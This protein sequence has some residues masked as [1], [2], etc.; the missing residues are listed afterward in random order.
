MAWPNDVT[1]KDL[2]I[3]YLRGSG[4]GGQKRQKTSSACRIHH[5]PTGLIGYAEDTR[6]QSTNRELAFNRLVTKLVPLIK[7]EQK[8]IR[9][10][11]TENVQN[12]LAR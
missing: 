8:K 1:K 4:N 5:I 6:S 11:V 7:N 9:Y 12:I 3:E 2:K 10:N